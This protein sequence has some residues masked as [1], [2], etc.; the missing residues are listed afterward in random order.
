MNNAARSHRNR[1]QHRTVQAAAVAACFLLL[2][3]A[4]ALAHDL[5][6]EPSAFVVDAGKLI[7][8]KLRVGVDLL[9]DPVPR[10]PALIDRFI[11]ADR[12]GIKPIIGRDG[13]D[14]AGLLRV[15]SPGLVIVGYAS[16]P[17]RIV[18]PANKFNEYLLEEG[19]ESVAALRAKR[20]QTDAEARESFARCAKAL[21]SSG[22]LTAADAD[23]ALGFTLELVAERNPY[24][25][26][27]GQSLPVRLIY[28]NKPLAGTLVVAVNRRN[29]SAKLSARSGKD[30]RVTFN[31]PEPGMWLIKAV[32]MTAA[33]PDA[34]SQWASYWASLTF[35]LPG[36]AAAAPPQR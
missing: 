31:L 24:A 25:L 35:E 1:R 34:E 16:T 29:P 9:G 5:W 2:T 4:S 21:I 27:A 3:G 30:G 12:A 8:I 13:E 19:L 23:R 22:P 11:A 15:T 26:Q 32:H 17:S 18:L 33:A 36:K 7:G 28:Q 10:D 6:I 20:N 14:P